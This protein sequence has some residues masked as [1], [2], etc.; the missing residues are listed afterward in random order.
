[1]QS[2]REQGRLVVR[3]QDNGLGLSAEQQG[4]LFRL[5]KRLHPHVEG[6]GMGLYLVKKILS[7]VGG[8][9]QVE[10]AVGRGTTFTVIF[11]T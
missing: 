7:H 2:F 9:I 10:S 6:T 11:P 5:F 4:Q 8:S 3:V 1:V